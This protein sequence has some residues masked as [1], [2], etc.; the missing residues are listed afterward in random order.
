MMKPEA[1]KLR[2]NTG[3]T[4]YGFEQM[5]TDENQRFVKQDVNNW[6]DPNQYQFAVPGNLGAL[7]QANKFGGGFKYLMN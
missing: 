7:K 1:F 3:N 4:N 6:D 5:L 2:S